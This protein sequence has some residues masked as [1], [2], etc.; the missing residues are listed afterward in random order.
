MVQRLSKA[1]NAAFAEESVPAVFAVGVARAPWA[2]LSGHHRI[3]VKK[4]IVG[5][6]RCEW[7]S[8]FEEFCASWSAEEKR[9]IIRRVR[10]QAVSADPIGEAKKWAFDIREKVR[11]VCREDYI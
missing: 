4:M 9:E 1:L 5:L 8:Q 2:Q 7:P 3:T 6:P 10:E 11:T